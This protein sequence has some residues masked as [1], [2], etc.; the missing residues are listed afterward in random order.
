MERSLSESTVWLTEDEGNEPVMEELGLEEVSN[1]EG[2][3]VGRVICRMNT[4]IASAMSTM[5]E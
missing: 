5:V 2:Y 4:P 3:R 1:F